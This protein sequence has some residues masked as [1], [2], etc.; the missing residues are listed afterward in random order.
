[1]RILY[2]NV[3]KQ[4]FD[5]IMAKIKKEDYREIKPY[6]SNRFLDIGGPNDFKSWDAVHIKNG[7]SKGAPL[8]LFVFNGIEI[9]KPNPDWAPGFP[10]DKPTFAVKLGELIESNC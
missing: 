1:M 9:K 10:C 5:L 4:Y 7:Y 2:L 6:W 8:G 3:K